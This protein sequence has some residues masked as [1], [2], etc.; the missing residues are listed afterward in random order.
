MHLEIQNRKER[1]HYHACPVELN[2]P[3]HL[4]QCWIRN[5]KQNEKGY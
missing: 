1:T 5:E 3:E 4:G 2:T